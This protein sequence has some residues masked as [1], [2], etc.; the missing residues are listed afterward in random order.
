MLFSVPAA[1]AHPWVDSCLWQTSGSQDLSLGSGPLVGKAVREEKEARALLDS[2]SYNYDQ[3]LIFFFFY[4][5]DIITNDIMA[6]RLGMHRR[7][8]IYKFEPLDVLSQE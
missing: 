8:I 4:Q 5:N 1:S 7:F 3:I 6:L 2:K